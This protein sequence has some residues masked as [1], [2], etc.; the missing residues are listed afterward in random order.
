M[1]MAANASLI[2]MRS[3]WSSFQAHDPQRTSGLL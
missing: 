2:S 1:T 3:I